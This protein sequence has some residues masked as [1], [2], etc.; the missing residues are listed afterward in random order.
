MQ[1]QQMLQLHKPTKGWQ[2]E[3]RVQN[4]Q[5]HTNLNINITFPQNSNH[6]R[7]FPHIF[8]TFLKIF[9]HLLAHIVM[10]GVPTFSA[11]QEENHFKHIHDISKQSL[12]CP[13]ISMKFSRNSKDLN[14]ISTY[15]YGL[16]ERCPSFPQVT[17]P[18][19]QI[20]Y[21]KNQHIK[22][23]NLFFD[24]RCHSNKYIFLL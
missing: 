18:L 15:F 13:R 17:I 22:F 4:I 8:M 21:Y 24:L 9:K 19:P 1:G 5:R 20:N 11:T 7:A 16:Q 3:I 12:K 23:S 10:K 6:F 2:L 14:N